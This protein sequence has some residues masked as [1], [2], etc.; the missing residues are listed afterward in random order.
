MTDRTLHVCSLCC[1]CWPVKSDGTFPT[2]DIHP[3]LRQVCDG[4]EHTPE[5]ATSEKIRRDYYSGPPGSFTG[6]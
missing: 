3:N 5:W 2:H 1:R 4:S 6:D